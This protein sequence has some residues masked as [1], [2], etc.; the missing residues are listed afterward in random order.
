MLPAPTTKT[1]SLTV[2]LFNCVNVVA[3]ASVGSTMIVQT[4][5]VLPAH[6]VWAGVTGPRH[7][8]NRVTVNEP[9]FVG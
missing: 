2:T 8:L 5:V 3:T 4:L 6:A 1:E 9:T 7:L